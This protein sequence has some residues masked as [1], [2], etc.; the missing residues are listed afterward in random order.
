[1]PRCRCASAG[2]AITTVEASRDRINSARLGRHD[3]H[4]RAGHDAG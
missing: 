4:T 2:S 3:R 1:V